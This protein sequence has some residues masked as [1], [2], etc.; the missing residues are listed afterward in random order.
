[1]PTAPLSADLTPEEVARLAVDF[2]P[3]RA[4]ELVAFASEAFGGRLVLTCSWQIGT[5]ILVHMTR[6]VAPET[7]LVEIDTGLL[8][9]ESHAT[10]E[11]L[12]DHYGLEVETLRPLQSVE[13]QAGT[14]GDAL[15]E[16]DPDRCCGLRKVAPLEQAIRDADG[17][18]TGIRRDQTSSRASAPKLVLDARRGVVKV[19]PLVD[20]SERDCWRYI[21]QNGIPYNELHDRGFPSIG[22][23]PCTRAAAGGEDAR[24]GRWAGSGKSECGLHVV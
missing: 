24:A 11:R 2:E 17:W 6:Q 14:H 10:R 8:F 13:E 15:W 3:L 4:E 5:S 16:R 1:M 21:Y 20:W 9:A 23:T 19:Q 12:V 18:L 22:C 7:R